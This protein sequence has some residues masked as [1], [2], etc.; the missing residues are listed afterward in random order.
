MMKYVFTIIISVCF[1]IIHAQVKVDLKNY[2]K[3]NGA[4]VRVNK[5]KIFV[6]WPVSK[7][8]KGYLELDLSNQQPLFT[9]IGLTAGGM[10]K[11]ISKNLDPVFLL[12]VGKRDLVSQNGWNIFFDKVPLKPHQSHVLII[13]KKSASVHSAGTRTMLSIGEIIAPGFAGTIEITLYNGSPL[14]NVA[15][16]MSTM[17]DSTAIVYDAGLI[18]K[19]ISWQNISWADVSDQMQN[20][21]P[22]MA[23]SSHNTAVKYR[24]IFGVSKN[25]SLAVFPAPH[26]YFYPLDEAFNL[27]FIWYGNNY[28]KTI[29][30]YGL[31][32][33]Q[34]LYGDKRFVPWFNSPPGTEQ[35]LNFFCLL[36]NGAPA[37]ALDQVKK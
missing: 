28:R 15:A 34:D 24:S 25:G 30:G 3:K 27:K 2:T 32:I 26:Q 9:S 10:V 37:N 6:S 12:T 8:Q 23:D 16:V 14:F 17:K 20:I 1:S 18:S 33:R 36:N 11:E 4:E 31:G 7:N 13:D 35:R 29:N 19:Q 22:S 21:Q 5:N